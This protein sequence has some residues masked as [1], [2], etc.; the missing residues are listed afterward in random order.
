MS[1]GAAP[2]RRRGVHVGPEQHLRHPVDEERQREGEE[3][4]DDDALD[5]PRPVLRDAQH[6]L[7]VDVGEDRHDDQRGDDGDRQRQPLDPVQVVH[8]ERADHGEVADGQV[9]DVGDPVPDRDADGEHRVDRAGGDPG[10]EEVA[11]LHHAAP[12]HAVPRH[13]VAHLDA[14]VAQGQRPARCLL[15]DDQ[16]GAGRV[17]LRQH[18]VHP[19]GDRLGE[20]E[21]R[22]VDGEDLRVGGQPAGDRHHLLLAAGQGARQLLEV[23]LQLGEQVDRTAVGVRSSRLPDASRPRVA[24]EDDVV[25]RGQVRVELAALGHEGE[26]VPAAQL[27]SPFLAGAP[28]ISTSPRRRTMPVTPIRIEDLPLPFGP[29]DRA[30]VALGDGERGVVHRDHVPVGDRQVRTASATPARD[31]PL[32]TCRLGVLRSGAFRWSRS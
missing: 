24:A 16:R 22:L 2:Q 10:D 28:K 14:P 18:V 26:A 21:A 29:D 11:E 12:R 1:A 15:D 32:S 7:V 30:G 6:H 23:R 9:E 31:V 5:R 8:A 17:D 20:A 4:G 27:T 3:E 13:S 19:L 25:R